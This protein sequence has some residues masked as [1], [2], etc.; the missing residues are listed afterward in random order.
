MEKAGKTPDLSIVIVGVKKDY[1]VLKIT[2]GEEMREL[3]VF[4]EDCGFRVLFFMETEP[5]CISHVSG[6]NFL[7]RFIFSVEKNMPESKPMKFSSPEEA[8]VILYEEL[9]INSD[10]VSLLGF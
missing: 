3:L 1:Y 10:K 7:E 9:S 8:I 2:S 6:K 5:L 4:S